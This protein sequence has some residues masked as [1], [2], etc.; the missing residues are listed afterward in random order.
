[1]H[2]SLQKVFQNLRLT[3]F[4]S[5][6]A[7]PYS[8]IRH[9][10]RWFELELG[11]RVPLRPSVTFHGGLCFLQR[12]QVSSPDISGRVRQFCFWRCWRIRVSSVRFPRGSCSV[13]GGMVSYGLSR[14]CRDC[15][16]QWSM[17]RC[18]QH[19]TGESLH[20]SRHLCPQPRSVYCLVHSMRCGQDSQGTLGEDIG[21]LSIQHKSSFDFQGFWFLRLSGWCTLCGTNIRRF[22]IEWTIVSFLP[23]YCRFH[24]TMCSSCLFIP[25]TF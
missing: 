23:I 22:C 9:G 4:V 6:F 13:S 24:T 14:T 5:V 18:Q 11:E 12:V 2:G 7:V 25:E 15:S 8:R 19:A 20:V 3:R 16:L 21:A 17:V 1:M 10:G